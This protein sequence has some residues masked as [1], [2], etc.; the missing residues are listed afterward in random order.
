[1]IDSDT[2]KK[3]I[4]LG[5]KTG[6]LSLN[7]VSVIKTVISRIEKQENVDLRRLQIVNESLNKIKIFGVNV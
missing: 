1:M 2:W 6:K 3:V 5:E 4:A 7:E